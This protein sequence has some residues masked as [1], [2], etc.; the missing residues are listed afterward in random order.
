MA[1][2]EAPDPSQ[3][4]DLE[5]F[6]TALGELRQWAG[7]PSYRMLAKRV[8]PLMRPPQLIAHTTVSSVFQPQRR[9]LD[10]DLVTTIVRALGVPEPEVARWRQ[11]C[12]QVHVRAKAGD[13]AVPLRQLPANLATLTGRDAELKQLLAIA[14]ATGDAAKTVVVSAI[15]GMA[16][17]GKT[18]LAVHAAHL[19][20]ENFPDGQLF[21]DLHAHTAGTGPR[22]PNEALGRLLQ[23]LGLDPQAIPPELDERAKAFRNR[24]AG[25]RTLIVLDDAANEQQ[26]RPLIPAT[27]GCLVL[28]TSRNRLKA[29][30]DA[31]AVPLDVLDPADAVALLCR[32]AGPGRIAAD[33]PAV[34]R[35]AELC[36]YLPLALRI[37]ATNLAHRPAWTTE[38]LEARLRTGLAD[39]AAFDDG[40]RRVRAAFDLSYD[41]LT[42]DQQAMFRHLGLVPGQDSD[43]YA[44]AA[45]LD[46]GLNEADTLLQDL[47]DRS[48]LTETAPGR[49]RLHDL[50]REHARTL[51][52]THESTK[53]RTTAL[54]RLLHYY[55]HTAQ[56][57]STA[58][59][60]L[61]R[62]EPDGPAPAHTPDLTD[63]ETARAWLRTEHRNLDDAHTQARHLD[64]HTIALTAGMAEILLSDGPWVRALEVHQGAAEAAARLDRPAAHA[65][66]LTDL[67]RLRRLTGDSPGAADDFARAL[68]M[69]RQIGNR[70][71]EANALT[72]LGQVRYQGGDVPGAADTFAQALEMFRQIGN[73][74][75]EA[76]ALINLGRVRDTS[77]DYPGAADTHMRALEI[78]QKIGNRLGE[79]SALNELGRVAHMNADFV[80][81]VD[82][83]SQALEIFRRI[84][85]RLGEANALNDIGRV[86]H[87]SGDFAGALDAHTRALEVFRQIGNRLGEAMALHDLGRARFLTG[88]YPGA[89]QAHTQALELYRQLGNRGNE[90][91]VLTDLGR[92]RY[93]TGDFQGAADTHS[94][95]LE[96]FRQIG[97][98]GNEAWAL[99]FYAAAIA[100]L[101]DRP[102][103][104]ALYEQ[105]LAMNRELHKPD[106]EAISLE[107]I[108]DHYLATGDP[109]QGLAYMG[110][111]LEIYRRLG[112]RA[113]TERVQARLAEL[114]AR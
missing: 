39:L 36:G 40:D 13:P 31:H 30:D 94:Q 64:D 82:A 79:A 60:R 109:A 83:H 68:E 111:A 1:A 99:N 23:A 77:G 24:L 80:G 5:E 43:L 41:N 86:G 44:A 66:A 28:V 11:A 59:A 6:I 7:G 47:T 114:E 112:M 88:D 67:G 52:A 84:G 75:G 48:L 62:P 42:P 89:A 55:A 19:A 71:G 96:A 33:D 91:S 12:V 73:R 106:D 46:T 32:H 113:D 9:R 104:F 49:Y 69:F 53:Q 14:A 58:I 105:A 72:N 97:Y 18:A 51:A 108:A 35:I 27:P 26:V 45:L 107:G 90:A 2:N 34:A 102:R 29:L 4:R 81:A 10:I 25:S 22:D 57:A 85:N 56:T 3:V 38:H 76:N 54:D 70:L 63:P 100:A 110:Q 93:L 74:L 98:R 61:P 37:T 78:F 8:G 65:T 101:G 103:A 17:I 21:V 50:L 15:D 16:G 92:V 20:A 87:Q 95:A